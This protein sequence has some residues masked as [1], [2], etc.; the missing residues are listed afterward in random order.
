MPALARKYKRRLLYSSHSLDN[1]KTPD[2]M[3]PE[4]VLYL[5]QKLSR[6]ATAF[7]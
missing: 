5:H 1:K 6:N 7:T 3:S 2:I 4:F